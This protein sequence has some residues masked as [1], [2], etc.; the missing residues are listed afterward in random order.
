MRT[1]KIRLA[2]EEVY[3]C[4]TM[5]LKKSLV[6]QKDMDTKEMKRYLQLSKKEEADFDKGGG[7]TP[8]E[9]EEMVKLNEIFSNE[10]QMADMTGVV[11]ESISVKHEQFAF[12]LVKD[13]NNKQEVK[14][15]KEENA[16]RDD[17]L[18]ELLDMRDAAII[19]N[20]AI[21]GTIAKEDVFEAPVD[22]I[23]LAGKKDKK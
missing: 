1:L 7:L 12:V 2:D 18:T 23:D 6:I 17:L 21:S 9:M 13:P 8:E 4:R 19:F 14:E 15:A 11:R 10:K 5:S 16:R 3:T 20:F 22:E